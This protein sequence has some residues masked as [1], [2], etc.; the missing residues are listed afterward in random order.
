MLTK[1]KRRGMIHK[2][3]LY[4]DSYLSVVLTGTIAKRSTS[5]VGCDLQ[6]YF[7]AKKRTTWMCG[8]G[9]INTGKEEI[10]NAYY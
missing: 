8:L 3:L 1:E 10:T 2:V 4:T 6:H 5:K 9:K 7:F